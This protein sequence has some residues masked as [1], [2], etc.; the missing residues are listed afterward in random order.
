MSAG[1]YNFS[2]IT[3]PVDLWS[4]INSITRANKDY[5]DSHFRPFYRTTQIIIRPTNTKPWL[6]QL[7]FDLEPIQFSSTLDLEFLAQALRLQNQ[8]SSLQG[9]LEDQNGTRLVSLHDICFAPLS[10]D[11]TN[12]TIQTIFNYWQ[13]NEQL[14]RY[15]QLDDFNDTLADYITHFQGCVAAPTTVNDTMG[16]SCLGEFGGT[17]MPYVA[18]GGYPQVKNTPQYGNATALVITYIINNHKDPRLTLPAMAWEK[19][20]IEFLKNYSN[21][22]MTISFSTERSVQDELD[23]ESKSDVY[24]ILISY[25]AMFLYITLTLGNYSIFDR[26]SKSSDGSDK[27][28]RRSVL[29]RCISCFESFMVDMKFSLGIAGVAIVMLSVSASIG[30]FSYLSVK[31]TLIIFEVIPFLVLAVGVDNIFILVQNYQRVKRAENETLEEQISRIVGKVGPS[32]LLTSSAESLAF[33]LGALTPM[34]AVRIFSLY[35]ALAVFI[36]FILQITCF[37]SLMTLDCRRELANRYNFCCCFSKSTR[38]DDDELGGSLDRRISSSKNSI[39]ATSQ[40]SPNNPESPTSSMHKPDDVDTTTAQPIVEQFAADESNSSAGLLF[41]LFKN[42]YAPFLLNAKV[43]PIVIITFLGLF[44]TSLAL[45]PKVEIGLD[46]KLSMPKDSYVLDYFLALEKYL[47][48]G[49]PVYFV[50]KNVDDYSLVP[51]QNMIC[52]SAGCDIDSM[53][54]QINQASLQPDYTTIAV[55]A[56]SWLDDYFDWLSSGDCCRVHSNGSFCP[57]TSPDYDQCTACSITFQSDTNRPIRDDF[58]KYFKFYISDNPGI[59]CAKGG[60]AAYGEAIEM[61]NGTDGSYSIGATFFMG[62]HK[63]GVTSKDFI[64]SLKNSLDISANITQSM[65][66]KMRTKTNDTNLIDSIEVVPYSLPY[67]FYE[68]YLTIWHDAAFNLTISLLAIFIVSTILLGLDFYSSFLISLTIAMIVVNM[69][70]ALYLFKIELNA[71]SLV[72]LVMVGQHL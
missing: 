43:R 24:T 50:L 71:V 13:N 55:P 3:D 26:K 20:V 52:S 48:V 16:L 41:D 17:I 68:Q 29:R 62:Y 23:R 56:N 9:V 34:P 45:L 36:D 66:D 2:V 4:P 53:L 5:Y 32:M 44:C 39:I 25:M 69:F 37:V 30:F 27:Y 54:N 38:T 11:N 21:P 10:P 1:F 6:H 67:V 31:A 47:S 51:R 63:V 57:S 18:L 33:L 42:Y 35:A 14:L 19:S 49:V 70:G 72:N 7:F 12:C 61:L 28:V 65:R 64:D 59:K 58:Y 15:Q 40:P 8:V 60:H 22:N 46:Q